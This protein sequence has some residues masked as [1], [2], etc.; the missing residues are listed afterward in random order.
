MENTEDYLVKRDPHILLHESHNTSISAMSNS[1]HNITAIRSV[2]SVFV[3][4][5][6]AIA[7]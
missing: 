1:L 6:E 5:T 3:P 4:R 7:H 2:S